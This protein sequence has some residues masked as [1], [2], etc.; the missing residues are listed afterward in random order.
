MGWR[1]GP[2][3]GTFTYGTTATGVQATEWETLVIE[4]AIPSTTQC[5][6]VIVYGT[7][8]P[9]SL[10]TPAAGQW[11]LD[12]LVVE[13]GTDAD[14]TGPAEY[15]DGDT[16]E[17]DAILDPRWTGTPGASTSELTRGGA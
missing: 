1:D 12:S 10:N 3:S 6:N 4:S 8:G 9:A 5:I 14:D 7:D 13:V 11:A 2:T 17:G 15:F 16:W